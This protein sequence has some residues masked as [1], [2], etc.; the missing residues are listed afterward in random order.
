MR[1]DLEPSPVVLIQSPDPYKLRQYVDRE[2]QRR[3]IIRRTDVVPVPGNPGMWAI[4]VIQLRKPRPRWIVPGAVAAGVAG[5]GAAGWWLVSTV[6]AVLAGMSMTGLAFAAILA[7]LLFWPRGGG[8]RRGS[9]GGVD[10]RVRWW[11]D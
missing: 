8:G 3:A 10:I 2:L 4:E 1:R 9:S 11:Q 7:A 6:T 5:V